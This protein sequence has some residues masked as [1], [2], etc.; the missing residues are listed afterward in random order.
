[1]S[2]IAFIDSFVGRLLVS[3]VLGFW[4]R[5]IAAILV[6]NKVLNSKLRECNMVFSSAAIR[7]IFALETRL[8]AEPDLKNIRRKGTC[9]H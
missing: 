7:R 1:M 6:D 9:H 5:C 3:V 2:W 4:S 8:Q